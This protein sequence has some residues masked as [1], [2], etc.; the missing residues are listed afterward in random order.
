MR[1]RRDWLDIELWP[2]KKRRRKSPTDRHF[3]MVWQGEMIAG[4]IIGLPLL[5]L[6][7][8]FLIEALSQ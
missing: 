4:F 3:R 6:L 5:Y 7:L 2:R 8:M 1:R